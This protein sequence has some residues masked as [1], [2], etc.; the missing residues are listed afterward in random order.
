MKNPFVAEKCLASLVPT[1]LLKRARRSSPARHGRSILTS[2]VIALAIGLTFAGATYGETITAV[3][4]SYI[5]RDT[6]TTNYGTATTLRVKNDNLSGYAKKAYMKFDLSGLNADPTGSATLTLTLAVNATAAF[7]IDAFGLNSGVSGFD[8]VE[9]SITWNNAPG[10]VDNG[11]AFDP[12]KTTSVQTGISVTNGTP[13]G[14]SFDFSLS[15]LV[16]FLQADDT[17][18]LMVRA[19]TITVDV[20]FFASKEYAT[21][22]GPKLTYSVV[23]PAGTVIIIK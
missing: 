22:S 9:T 4:D 3:G 12:A 7:T 5:S 1:Y 20:L 18:T 15:S 19:D 13:A 21:Y 17:V 23:P 8:W 11:Y 6:K 10:N 14:T 2:L 16:N